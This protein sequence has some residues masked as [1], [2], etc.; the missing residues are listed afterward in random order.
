M[1]INNYKGIETKPIS[2][3]KKLQKKKKKESIKILKIYI[4]NIF[5][6]D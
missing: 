1:N 2:L 6:K 5:L 4:Q 3:I